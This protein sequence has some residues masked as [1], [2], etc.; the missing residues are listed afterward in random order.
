M[1]KIGLF[2]AVVLLLLFAS[3]CNNDDEVIE[4]YVYTFPLQVGNY[5]EMLYSRNDMGGNHESIV[6]TDT[7]K[8]WAEAAVESPDGETCIKMKLDHSG[9]MGYT[10]CMYL[11]NR[12]DGLYI[13]GNEFTSSLQTDKDKATTY[14]GFLSCLNNVSNSKDIT[15]FDTPRLVIPHIFRKG[16]N[17]S[18]QTGQYTGE[19]CTMQSKTTVQTG[20]GEFSC[21]TRETQYGGCD[22]ELVLISYEYF[23]DKGF[24]KYRYEH[25]NGTFVY[26]EEL[27]LQN[28]SI[29]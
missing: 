3:S 23:C 24:A 22:P 21:F 10:G 12:A 19:T 8:I 17:W 7:L 18:Y 2:L 26:F 15:W 9:I 13:L 11:V 28:C 29:N 20:C 16:D 4:D 14:R 27:L 6:T 5:W 1:K 25:E